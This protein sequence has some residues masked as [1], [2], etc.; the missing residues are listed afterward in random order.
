[1]QVVK[2]YFG[3]LYFK[4][5]FLLNY[6][7]TPR[8]AAESYKDSLIYSIGIIFDLRKIAFFKSFNLIRFIKNA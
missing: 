8:H 6:T 5:I 2:S 7:A 1:M 3:I 4:V